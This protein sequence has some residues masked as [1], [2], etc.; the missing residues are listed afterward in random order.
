M[1]KISHYCPQSLPEA[2][3]LLRE[4]PGARVLAG[5]TD[6]VAKWKKSGRADLTL[7]G[8]RRIVELGEL[9]EKNGELFIGATVTMDRLADSGLV[10]GRYPSLSKAA[11]QVG[12]VQIR[13]MATIGGNVC[14]AAPSADTVPPLIIH[15][16]EAVIASSQA[17][18]RCPLEDFFLGPGR[19]ALEPGE[20]LKGVLLPRSAANSADI[21]I[22]HSRRAGMDLAIVG[23]ALTLT[24]SPDGRQVAG[25]RLAL[26]AV[27]PTPILVRGLETAGRLLEPWGLL[28]REVADRAAEEARP[29]TDVRGSREYRLAMVRATAAASFEAAV[30]RLAPAA[31]EF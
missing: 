24:L 31:R 20:I 22:K 8:I 11:S 4:H 25:L 27:G 1:N 15:R 16:A 18:R 3:T 7:I 12:S 2:L 14:N 30:R 23:V 17:E 26:G 28:G 6:L 13:N 29:I 21:F 19:P 5:G 9:F 10:R